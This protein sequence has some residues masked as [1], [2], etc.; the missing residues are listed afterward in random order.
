MVES[1]RKIG[2]FGHGFTY[3]G[4]P[5]SAAV[6]V[7]TLQLYEERQ[8]FAHAA[9]VAEY[10]QGR[11][12]ALSDHGLVG[13]ARGVGLIGGCEMVADRGTGRAF[14]NP[15]KVGAYCLDRCQEHGLIVRNIGDTIALCP[16]LVITESEIGELFDR[17]E[18][19]LDDTLTWV[20]REALR[21]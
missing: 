3:S 2:V 14:A 6:A 17:L 15:G 18:R 13:E 12:A 11:L 7:R 1:S 5:V 10:F 16:P 4:H 20:E 19:A 8:I 9:K 21:G